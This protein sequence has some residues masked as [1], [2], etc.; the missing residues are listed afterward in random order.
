[1][2]SHHTERFGAGAFVDERVGDVFGAALRGVRGDGPAV[3]DGGS[4]AAV[5]V[6]GVEIVGCED[7]GVDAADF[8]VSAADGFDDPGVTVEHGLAHRRTGVE[9]VSAGDD[10]VTDTDLEIFGGCVDR[11]GPSVEEQAGLDL[12]VDSATRRGMSGSAVIGVHTGTWDP[13]D[14]H[15][16]E[17]LGLNHIVGTAYEFIGCYSARVESSEL[18][19]GLGVCWRKE[20]IEET[21]AARA[22]AT[23]PHIF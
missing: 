12:G 11:F 3:L 4:G 1:M 10:L 14:P 7:L 15:S 8:E 22:T 9:V 18:E 2:G 13:K 23:N 5:W 21:C 6:R 20:V 17:R 16:P 19:A